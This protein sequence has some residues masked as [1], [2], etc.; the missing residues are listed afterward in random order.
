LTNAA[1]HYDRLLARH[2]TWM[3]GGIE[4]AV[5]RN[6]QFFSDNEL[7]QGGGAHAIDLGAGSGAQ[8]IAL[9]RLGYRVSA[10][11]TSAVLLAELRTH[12]TDL[13]IE[14][15]CCDMRE[16]K[17]H[18][19]TSAKIC[20][21]MG[22]TLT[23]LSSR[24]E[25]SKL[26]GDI[27]TTLTVDGRFIVSF[28]DLSTPLTGLDRFLPVRSDA[29]KIFTCMVERDDRGVIVHDL[30]HERKGAEWTLHK[31]AYRKIELPANWIIQTLNEQ[32]FTVIS[33]STDRGL[34]T[35]IAEK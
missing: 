14:T 11:D 13:T 27:Y 33:V 21:C 7:G 20:V 29:D 18:C 5:N 17:R 24:N 15:T 26:I 2:Y 4:A 23:H 35:I 1:E 8:S 10:I 16:F 32:E 30:V 28:R 31:S 6:R 25:V 22:D 3:I 34:T 19:D 12:S 9:A